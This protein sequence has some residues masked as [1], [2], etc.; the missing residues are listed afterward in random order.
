MMS[1]QV[2]VYINNV[3]QFV[4]DSITLEQVL[5]NINV[6]NNGIAIAVNNAV[7]PKQEWSTKKIKE[8][9]KI[10]IIKATQGG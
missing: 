6:N 1:K 2:E 5:K 8:K 10:L 9:D 7:I 3:P 4:E